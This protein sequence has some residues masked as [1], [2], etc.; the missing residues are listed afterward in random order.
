MRAAVACLHKG[1]E[2]PISG[3]KGSGTVFFSG[4]TLQCASC[5]NCQLSHELLGGTITPRLLSEI[6]M[7]LERFGAAN[8]NLVTA[9]QWIP[10]ILMALQSAKN[11]GM[12]LPV[13]WNSSGY[14]A[15]ET[16]ELLNNFIDIYLPDLKTI[17]PTFSKSFLGTGDYAK[18]AQHAI[19]IMAKSKPLQWEEETLVRGV[20][21]RHLVLP[22]HI[23]ASKKAIE[24]IHTAFSNSVI[25][26]LMSQYIPFLSETG[27]QKENINRSLTKKEYAQIEAFIE[28]LDIENGFFQ[29]LSTDDTWRPDF[30]KE[31]PFPSEYAVPV[32]HYRFGFVAKN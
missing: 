18:T 6:F 2:P 20:I 13:V 32:W 27:K 19:G 11:R 30:K 31:N 24:W 25:I 5:Q 3:T 9:T 16:L 22:G 23:A 1:E 28:T 10:H 17:S 21:V 8:I 12:N 4:C 7:E 29:A 26:S 15:E 14:E